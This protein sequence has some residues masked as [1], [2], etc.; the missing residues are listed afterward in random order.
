MAGMVS[1]TGRAAC[2]GLAAFSALPAFGVLPN[3]ATLPNLLGLTPSVSSYQK[4]H[5][6]S[7]RPTGGSPSQGDPP[8][9]WPPAG[10]SAGVTGDAPHLAHP[11]GAG[12]GA[13]GTGGNQ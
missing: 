9:T 5:G 6:S 2:S 8:V 3:L 4:N 7:A 12:G 13:Q 1:S 11:V 10:E